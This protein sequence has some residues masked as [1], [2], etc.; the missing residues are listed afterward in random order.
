MTLKLTTEDLLELE[1]A[2]DMLRVYT[3]PG[4]PATDEQRLASL[5]KLVTPRVL[6]LLS[7]IHLELGRTNEAQ[8]AF[9]QARL[10]E[11]EQEERG[12]A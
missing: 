7:K 11:A 9:C 1:N 10:A 3:L 5:R 12:G 8:S 6:L 2:L 4:F